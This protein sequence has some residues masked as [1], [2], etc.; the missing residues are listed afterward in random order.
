MATPFDIP[1]TAH[2]LGVRLIVIFEKVE[3]EKA[4]IGYS[5]HFLSIYIIPIQKLD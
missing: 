4:R 5:F 2:S 1:T 3:L